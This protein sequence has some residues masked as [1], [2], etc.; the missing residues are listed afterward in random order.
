[1]S[2]IDEVIARSRQPG[3]FA[4]RKRFSVA[5][6]RGIQKMR[7][8]ALASPVY[9]I[10]ELIQAAIANN[11][12]YVDIDVE[13]SSVFLTYIGGNF[14]EEE[15]GQL[16]DFL[17]A[18][19]ER[20]EFADVRQLA[21]GVNALMLAE[22]DEVVIE[23]GDGTTEG[24]TRIQIDGRSD[25]VEVG[26]PQQP[27]N[28]TYLRATG[29][30]RGKL[31]GGSSPRELSVIEE[32]CLTAPIPIIVNTDPI[33]GYTSDRT[34]RL[35]GISRSVSFDEGELYGTIGLNEYSSDAAVFKLLTWGVWIE[36]V[37]YPLMPG[38][39]MCG[40]VN[41]DRLH[42]TVD[43]S[44][45]VQDERLGEMWTRLLP[46]ARQLRSGQR[47]RAVFDISLHDGTKLAATDIR[48][49][50]KEHGGA[51]VI[52]RLKG[53]QAERQLERAQAFSAALDLPVLFRGQD[54]AATLRLLGGPGTTVIEPDVHDPAE[55]EFYRQA[56]AEPPARPWLTGAIDLEPLTVADLLPVLERE[57]LFSGTDDKVAAQRRQVTERLRE[58]SE[59][60]ATVYTPE[61][62]VAEAE[63]WAEVRTTDR[64]VWTGSIRCPFPGHTLVIRLP[65]IA[66]KVLLDYP[67]G[68]SGLSLGQLM[69]SDHARP[70]SLA[71]LVARAVSR[72]AF[73]QLR[74]ATERVLAT[75]G[76]LDEVSRV[77]VGSAVAHIAL[78][79]LARA[80]I[81]RLRREADGALRI[82]F[83][84]LDPELPAALLDVP[85]L[86]T[87][88]G[89]P[90]T[91]RNL[92]ALMEATGGLAYG[93]VPRVTPDL[94][95]LDRSRIF[96]LDLASERLLISLVGEASYVR[97]DR[98]DLMAEAGGLR[99]RDF[100]LGLRPF[101][102]FPLLVEGANPT[103]LSP[104]E[105]EGLKRELL[106]QL[107]E[108]F[109]GHDDEEA[110]R[111]AARHLIWYLGAASQEA[112][113]QALHPVLAD[114]S[115]FLTEDGRACSF[116]EVRAA[117]ERPDG[118]IM[119]DGWAA[120]AAD[121][122]ALTAGGRSSGAPAEPD[123]PLCLAMNPFVYHVLS[124]LGPI[125]PALDLD[126]G[127]TAVE[128]AADLDAPFLARA[129]ISDEL[130][131][132]EVGVPLAKVRRPAV[133]VVD[134]E[135][136]RVT[137]L[138]GAARE[139]GV[140]G[141]LR[142]KAQRIDRSQLERLVHEASLRA[143]DE[144]VGRISGLDPASEEYLCAADA[145][146]RYA[147]RSVRITAEPDGTLALSLMDYRSQAILE[148]PLLPTTTGL[149]TSPH[150]LLIEWIGRRNVGDRQWRPPL[151]PET[152]EPLR[153]RIGDLL[154]DRR[155][156]YPASSGLEAP[157]GLAPA[158]ADS[159]DS[160]SSTKTA[161]ER[162]LTDTLA[163]LRTDEITDAQP[164][165]VIIGER[166]RK[167]VTA[168]R[169]TI[170]DWKRGKLH[171]FTYLEGR[172][173]L[174]LDG[175]HWLVRRARERLATD[176][177]APVWLLLACY[178]HIN[179]VLEPVSNEHE[180]AFH[181][182]VAELLEAGKLGRSSR[183]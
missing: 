15:L 148:L 36:T 159:P 32:R 124:R 43:H 59:I 21:L 1:M 113:G 10:L 123:G 155:V 143:L 168:G 82:R 73:P 48:R 169:H 117:F 108:V 68:T 49:V 111:Q 100:A 8:F 176:P 56:E 106:D 183:R 88:T 107:I 99:C 86:R 103:R 22:P 89:E 105:R 102:R 54:E 166:D 51:V 65:D 27:L 74:A 39:E 77:E 115:L 131:E 45:V 69:T 167:I 29:L 7:K 137:M 72:L 64:T 132:G 98:R 14:T 95:G 44:A 135:R 160:T 50:M 170:S 25:T 145:L 16:F 90:R 151:S 120:D 75:L 18:S 38:V 96:D 121:L 5:R 60:R 110:R 162:W 11:A 6:Q 171:Q 61:R 4:E 156:V 62:P 177:E 173:T 33:F 47:G 34:P 150:R 119:S 40:V 101:P 182:R 130:V 104:D 114:L 63:L 2:S 57:G 164:T 58:S 79:A 118:L 20:L 66:P 140:V 83:S 3:A 93:V 92:A 97:V 9:Y 133:V 181:R 179:D 147:A 70:R 85:I 53:P 125:Q 71:A 87:L 127:S 175:G 84:P 144:L 112:Q 129:E 41:F 109:T 158:P 116:A 94:D 122:G 17:F 81:K 149:S 180:L 19:K 134:Q 78:A 138:T 152:P 37:R 80:S 128:T 126:V 178:A 23:S 52:P 161:L 24:T 30:D 142:L 76:H 163:R 46:Y 31:G 157:A 35:F 153:R 13:R 172:P 136:H 67:W 165:E 28:G 42:K 91:A 154:S 12:T 141:T 55:L 139:L 146:L 174:V 26:T